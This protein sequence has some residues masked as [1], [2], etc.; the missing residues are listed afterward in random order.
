MRVRAGL[1]SV[2]YKK[3][4]VLSNDERGRATG[5]IVN[6]MSVDATRLQDLCT[7]GL[8]S[9]SGPL[10]VRDILLPERFPSSTLTRSLLPLSLCTI[11]SAGLLSLEWPSWSSQFLS[12]LVRH[13]L[14]SPRHVLTTVCRYC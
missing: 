8:I 1:V 7:Y 4:L 6:L 11:C 13:C 14:V 3:A 2:I 10:Q 5:D 9:L 12:I